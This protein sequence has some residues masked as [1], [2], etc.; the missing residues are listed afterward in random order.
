MSPPIGA[1]M[2]SSPPASD[3]TDSVGTPSTNITAFTPSAPPLGFAGRVS[4]GNERRGLR[5]LTLLDTTIYR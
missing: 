1:A 5:N 3:E 2:A 4:T